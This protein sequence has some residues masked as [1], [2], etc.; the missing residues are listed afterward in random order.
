MWEEQNVCIASRSHQTIRGRL[1]LKQYGTA[2]HVAVF[3][4]S[5]G[6]GVIDTILAQHGYARRVATFVPHFVA[7]PFMVA[8]SD[9][10]ATVPERLARV[11]ARVLKLQ[12]LAAP[13]A[14]PPFRLAMLWHER[15]DR[16]AA[17]L[18]LRTLIAD[19][20]MKVK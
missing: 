13:L 18:W 9:L 16:D 15:N 6:P 20:A 12:V 2:G 3:Y 7:V 4:K 1:T 19:T 8:A 11:F 5:E 17:H 10:I 14:I